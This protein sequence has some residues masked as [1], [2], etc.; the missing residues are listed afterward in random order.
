MKLSRKTTRV[1]TNLGLRLQAFN[2]EIEYENRRPNQ[3]KRSK[4]NSRL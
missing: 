2:Q 1:L 3:R 4:N